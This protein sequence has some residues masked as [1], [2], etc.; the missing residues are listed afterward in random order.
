MSQCVAIFLNSNLYELGRKKFNSIE[1]FITFK[2]ATFNVNVD[3]FL[4]RNKDYTYYA[5][6]Y[7]KNGKMIMPTKAVS[8]QEKI[9]SADLKLVV[10]ENIIMQL[11]HAAIAMVKTN[12][13]MIILAVGCGLGVGLA[14]GFMI[15]HAAH[16]ANVVNN[17][18]N[19]TATPIP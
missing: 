16:A 7:E 8:V 1:P 19:A 2:D 17:Y 10:G 4:Y 5:Y 14:I 9:N 18:L 13:I 15:P 12:W 11:A 6:L 3:A